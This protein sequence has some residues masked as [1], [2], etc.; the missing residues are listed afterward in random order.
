MW[1]LMGKSLQR[2]YIYIYVCTTTPFIIRHYS[3]YEYNRVSMNEVIF[4]L[5]GSGRMGN[6]PP[7]PWNATKVVL[8]GIIIRGV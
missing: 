6:R 7:L 1:F 8:F 2:S 5:V 4:S 3:L